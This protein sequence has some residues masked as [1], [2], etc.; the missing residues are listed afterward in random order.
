M[1][2]RPNLWPAVKAVSLDVSA[3]LAPRLPVPA[4]YAAAAQWAKLESPPTQEELCPAF[5]KARQ[6]AQERFPCFGHGEGWSAR[7]WWAWTARTTLANCGRDYTEAEFNRFFRRV[8]QHYGSQGAFEE[9]ADAKPFLV[10]SPKW[11]PVAFRNGDRW[12]EDERSGDRGGPHDGETTPE[13][14]AADLLMQAEHAQAMEPDYDFES[15]EGGNGSPYLENR[16]E[17]AEP[18]TR[19]RDGHGAESIETGLLWTVGQ[20]SGDG[21]RSRRDEPVQAQQSRAHDQGPQAVDAEFSGTLNGFFGGAPWR[22]E[23]WDGM[24][25][26]A[27]QVDSALDRPRERGSPTSDRIGMLETLVYQLM[28]QNEQLRR[29]MIDTQSMSSGESG[30]G[31]TKVPSGPPPATPVVQ[32]GSGGGIV[33]GA[34]VVGSEGSEVG[35]ASEASRKD[36]IPGERTYWELPVLSPPSGEPNPAMRCNDWVYKIT[37]LMSDLAPR[38]NIWCAMILKEAQAAYQA[39]VIAKPLERAKIVGR[40]SEELQ[41]NAFTRIESRGVAMLSKALPSVVYEQALSCRNVSCVGLLFLTLRIYQPGGLN[42][43]AEL[44]RG[45]TTLQ[46]FDSPSVAVS[47]LQKWFRH[48]ERARTMEISIP[49]SSLLL[50]SIDKCVVPI[51]QAHP[52]LNFRM[53]TVRMQLQLD[54][55][56]LQTTVEEYTRTMLAELE[57]LAVAAPETNNAKRQRMAALA[58][59]GPKGKGS[60][61][62]GNAGKGVESGQPSG[63]DSKGGSSQRRTPCTGWITDKGCKYGKSCV[64]SH[65]AERQGKCWACGGAHQKAECAA[66]GGGKHQKPEGNDGGSAKGKDAKNKGAGKDQG[67]GS[68]GKAGNASKGN[69]QNLSGITPEAIKEAAQ[70]LQSMKL[71]SLRPHVESMSALL[72]KAQVAKGLIDGG[73][74]ACLRM[75]TEEEKGLPEV[76]VKLA[77]GECKLL[78]NRE[79]TLLSRS[80]VS[81]ILSVRAVLALGYRI[82]WDSSRCRVWHPT[83]GDL[84]VDD[85]SGCPEIPEATA[86][87]L[88]SQ[89]EEIVRSREIKC[90]RVHCIMQDLVAAS[91]E[92]LAQ[93]I[94]HRDTHADAAVQAARGRIRA[95]VA[96]PPSKTFSVCR[97]MQGPAERLVRPIRVRGESIGSYKIEEMS[98]QELAQRR[99]DDVLLMRMMA[100]MVVASA[101]TDVKGGPALACVVEHPEDVGCDGHTGLKES[102]FVEPVQGCASLWATPEWKAVAAELN[103]AGISFHQGPLGHAKAWTLSL[104]TAGPFPAGEDESGPKGPRYLVVGVLSIPILGTED[105]EA[106]V[107]VDRDPDLDVHMF[108]QHLEDEGWYLDQGC[109]PDDV[110]PE[111]TA[112]EVAEGNKAWKEWTEHVDKSQAEWL[113]EAKAQHLPKVQMVDYVLTEAVTSKRQQEVASAVGRMYAR[114]ISDGLSVQRVHTDRGRE[115]NNETLRT[116]CAKFGIH[117]TRAFAEEHQSNG[118]AEAAIM[119]IKGSTR[120][121]LQSSGTTLKEWPLAAKLAAHELREVTRKLLKMRPCPSMPFNTEMQVIQ[122]SWKRGVWE[123]LTVK[124]YTKCPSSDCS[125]GWVV[126]TEDGHLFTTNKLFPAIDGSRVKFE[127]PGSPVDLEAPAVR[128]K[129]KGRARKLEVQGSIND[130]R[131]PADI[132]ARKLYEGDQWEPKHIAS[133][134]LCNVLEEVDDASGMP[135]GFRV[136]ECLRVLEPCTE[137]AVQDDTYALDEV[138]WP[139]QVDLSEAIRSLTEAHRACY[140]M[141]QLFD[142]GQTDWLKE[143]ET[144]VLGDASKLQRELRVLQRVEQEGLHRLEVSQGLCANPFELRSVALG[145]I[146]DAPESSKSSG[147]AQSDSGASSD[148]DDPPPL[149]TKIVSQDQVRR[150]PHKWRGALVEELQSLT[151]KTEAVEDITD[152]QYSELVGDPQ[153]SVELI[154][155]KVVYN[156][157]PTGRRKARI[158]GC[159]NFCQS[160]TAS[161]KEDLFASGVGSESIRMMVRRA[162]LD[163]SWELASVDVRTA[164]LQAPLMEMQYEGRQKVTVVKVP[165]ILRELGITGAK[166]WRVKKALYGL[167]SAPKSWSL[168]RDRVLARLDIPCGDRTLKLVRM[169]EDANLWHVIQVPSQAEEPAGAHAQ[170]IGAVALYVDDILIGGPAYVT[171]AVVRALQSQWEL[172]A[173]E[174]LAKAGDYLKFAGYE[175][176]RTDLGYRLHQANYARD[177]LDQYREEILGTESTP[178]VKAY[179]ISGETESVDLLAVTRKAQAI[180]GQVLWLANRTR[181]DLVYGVNAAAQRIV[182]CPLEALARDQH[183]IRYIRHA[184][185]IGLHYKI[186]SEKCGRWDQLKFQELPT[187]IDAYSDASFAA[188]EQCR[189]FGCTQLFWGGALIAWSADRQTLIAAHTAECELYALGE[190]HLLGKA[191]RPTIAA[192]MNLSEPE[193]ESRLYCDDAAAIQLCVLEAGSWRARHLRLRGAVVRQDLESGLWK[194][195]HLDGVFMPAD[196][197][198]K[199]VGP[200]RLEDLIKVCDLWAPHLAESSETPRPQLASLQS[201]Q[202]DVAKA[203][204]ALLLLLQISGAAASSPTGEHDQVVGLLSG[205]VTGF[206]IGCGWWLATK[207][208]GFLDWCCRRRPVS[209]EPPRPRDNGSRDVWVQ[210]GLSMVQVALEEEDLVADPFPIQSE[211]NDPR[212]NPPWSVAQDTLEEGEQGSVLYSGLSE[213]NELLIDGFTATHLQELYEQ[214]AQEQCVENQA[215]AR[216]SHEV[217]PQFGLRALHG[218]VDRLITGEG[219]SIELQGTDPEGMGQ[220]SDRTTDELQSPVESERLQVQMWEQVNGGSWLPLAEWTRQQGLTVGV[221]TNEDARVLDTTLPMLGFHDFMRWFITSQEVGYQKPDQWIYVDAWREASLWVPG[222]RR[223]EILHVGSSYEEDFC[224]ARDAGL[225][226]LLLDRGAENAAVDPEKALLLDRGA[227]NAVVDPEKAADSPSPSAA[228]LEKTGEDVEVWTLRDLGEVQLVLEQGIIQQLR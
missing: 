64:F 20:S 45:L 193:I 12:T 72:R 30:R 213:G 2:P 137:L 219:P 33:Q 23:V 215:A 84:V 48:L 61:G 68:K 81:P 31:G 119:R 224:G 178:A 216:A 15:A 70:T 142:E 220:G 7:E 50:D 146:V 36:F 228:D 207:V 179:K 104:D 22:S 124:A 212:L 114:I 172:S 71:A 107:P 58:A 162:A 75:A 152:S 82:D 187:S 27:Q 46:V 135:A 102:S 24:V 51:L 138:G 95:I 134:A 73:A 208:G 186:P 139:V 175:L 156:H 174:R 196:M 21:S 59:D 47:G 163:S 29:E 26:P 201:K 39:W 122:R 209:F 127:Y 189:S 41:G 118:R 5:Q 194:L 110:V 94:V 67:S 176:V 3:L 202:T 126:R 181:P 199:P 151:Q 19:D 200:S 197:G 115:Y 42:E 203:L 214:L 74:T 121:I 97:Y 221:T 128:M 109:E 90:A 52:A 92:E 49:D 184:P 8:Y 169:P 85:S 103:L 192:L 206:G 86:L 210:A 167:A 143:C 120:T 63:V 34:Q 132:L 168:H 129:E 99:I 111:A 28:E 65:S 123:S 190:A 164:F 185:E 6:D 198:T 171:E 78:V 180:I 106:T 125:G 55:R 182:A 10:M 60:G 38:A 183:L 217:P 79:G 11:L 133:L 9:L 218:V 17:R 56:P 160:D 144:A 161:Q 191:M 153:I 80:F 108:A 131:H 150:E 89:F 157:K 226:A 1:S 188:D 69:A 18:R 113:E 76:S 100:F 101:A 98:S 53:H 96:A 227:E 83:K 155:G 62:S 158:V 25:G 147:E 14:E 195:T 44:L 159:G 211:G 170:R 4:V 177:L 16:Q 13:Q 32:Q 136:P 37:P 116:W 91:N 130:P 57:L 145:E 140:C 205:F 173:P 35:N 166:Y 105:Q 149:Q 165:S 112:K 87:S 77:C 223:E 148:P 204:L 225:Q 117:K 222:L 93:S 40:P 88:I 54:T 141:L 43:R 66:P 154:P